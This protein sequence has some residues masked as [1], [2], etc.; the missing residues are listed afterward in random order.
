MVWLDFGVSTP[1]KL[2]VLLQI[3]PGTCE[4]WTW[5]LH[6]RELLLLSLFIYSFF[7]FPL[8]NLN[9]LMLV[10]DKHHI[11][12]HPGVVPSCGWEQQKLITDTRFLIPCERLF[13][14]HPPKL[15]LSHMNF[16]ISVQWDSESLISKKIF[17]GTFRKQS[18]WWPFWV[19][20][21]AAAGIPCSG[22][23][24]SLCQ[25]LSSGK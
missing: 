3:L 10:L 14:L 1:I 8:N 23:L 9:S 13:L 24:T 2:S 20:F 5:W 4:E 19:L 12:K 15:Y 21:V 6:Q 17:L 16:F 11:S 18:S 22:Y 25:S 7:Y